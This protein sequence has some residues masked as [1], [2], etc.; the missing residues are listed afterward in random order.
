MDLGHLRPILGFWAW[1]FAIKGLFLPIFGGLDLS[2]GLYLG[3]LGP[4]SVVWA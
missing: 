2:L 4:I 3:N 1:I